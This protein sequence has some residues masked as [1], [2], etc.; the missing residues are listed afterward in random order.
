LVFT[1]Q[2]AEGI[3]Y[4]R[5]ID[6]NETSIN[7]TTDARSVRNHI[8]G[9]SPS[10]GAHSEI[11]IGASRER[12]RFLRVEAVGGRGPPGQVLDDQLTVA[13]GDGAVRADEAQRAGKSPMS[14]AEMMRGGSIRI[15][16]RFISAATPPSGR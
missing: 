10:P 16:D 15:G 11:E 13:C 12:I 4:A 8:H 14:G 7:W 6:K 1:P 2:R 5:K 3:L 9:L